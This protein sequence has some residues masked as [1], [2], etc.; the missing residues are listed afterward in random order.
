MDAVNAVSEIDG[1]G[2]QWVLWAT[3]HK[4]RQFGAAGL[5]FNRRAPI[6]PFGFGRNLVAAA[7]FKTG[8]GT[9][10]AVH[11]SAVKAQNIKELVCMGID[12]DRAG[13]FICGIADN[14]A[15]LER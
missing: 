1:A 4:F 7:P 6:W 8:L 5:H 12:N 10:H 15:T 3:C 14:F 13:L 9:G 2:T 11:H